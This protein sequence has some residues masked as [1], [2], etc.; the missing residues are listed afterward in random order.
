VQL[1]WQWNQV[2]FIFGPKVTGKRIDPGSYFVF[3]EFEPW[4]S[5]FQFQSIH[6]A[7]QCSKAFGSARRHNARA[8]DIVR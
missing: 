4:F 6:S 5:V 8:T 3:L 1:W 2:I 7:S